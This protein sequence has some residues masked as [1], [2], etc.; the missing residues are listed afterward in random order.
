[1]HDSDKNGTNMTMYEK[2]QKKF[3]IFLSQLLQR[4]I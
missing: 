4:V 2:I 1:M 3:K